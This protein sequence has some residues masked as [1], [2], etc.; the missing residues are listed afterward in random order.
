MNN[1]CTCNTCKGMC[2]IPCWGYP[3]QFKKLIDLGY[4]DYMAVDYFIEKDGSYTYLLCFNQKDNNSKK[5]SFA[6][7]NGK[8]IMQDKEGL[9]KV[10][11]IEKPAEG[12]N[13]HHDKSESILTSEQ[14]RELIKDSW[15]TDFGKRI[16]LWF[17]EKYNIKGV[18]I[19]V[20]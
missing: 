14:I 19:N 6:K 9:C 7:N 16:V 20:T 4:S 17:I 12:K 11:Y 18:N 8:C 2:R 5:M 10:H 13:A 1:S 3:Q 15:N